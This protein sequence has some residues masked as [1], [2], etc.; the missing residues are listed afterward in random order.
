MKLSVIIP[1][2]ND[3]NGVMMCLNSLQAMQVTDVEYIVSDDSS[4]DILFPAVI[5]PSIARCE[6]TKINLGFAGNCN[7]GAQYATGDVLMFVNQD[8]FGV[9]GWSDGWDG[10]ILSAFERSPQIGI[11]GARLF[12]PDGKIQNAGGL[13]DGAGQPF[14]RCLGYSNVHHPEVA[15]PMR[16][17]WTT[18][19]AMAVRRDVWQELHGFDTEFRMYFEDVDLCVRAA[20]AGYETWIEPR[21]TLIHRVGSTGGSVHFQ[22]SAQRFRSKWVDTGLI[23]PDVDVIREHFWA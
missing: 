6:R 3:L 1:A 16:V 11:V 2:Y 4:P 22:A 15:S 23:E 17:S 19:A 5:P 12:F 21:A 7:N 8:V 14:H 10:A 9:Y 13:F 18:G 20:K